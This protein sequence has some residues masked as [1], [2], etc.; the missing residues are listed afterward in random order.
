MAAIDLV[1]QAGMSS[2]RTHQIVL[3]TLLSRTPLPSRLGVEGT[4]LGDCV[5]EPYGGTFDLGLQ[6]QDAGPVFFE[7]KVT[8]GIGEDQIAKQIVALREKGTPDSQLI[9]CMI[10][11]ARFKCRRE[12]VESIAKRTAPK[13]PVSCVRYV[14]LEDLMRAL[15]GV[16]TTRGVP[17]DA[18]DLASAYWSCLDVLARRAEEYEK[19]PLDKWGEDHWLGFYTDLAGKL[20]I[21]GDWT[22][23]YVSNRAGGFMGM[24]WG[25]RELDEAAEAHAYLQF[26]D[27]KPCFKV[28]V[29]DP[30]RQS[31][32]R[33]AYW[34]VVVDR[35]KA[36]GCELELLRRLG[37]GNYMTVAR[38]PQNVRIT[39]PDGRMDWQKIKAL[40]RA[41]EKVTDAAVREYKK[42]A[43]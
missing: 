37:K 29:D 12:H 13:L 24:W 15:V 36:L 26:E 5:W 18:R 11:S 21:G 6:R 23:D 4:I 34:E 35:A 39:R 38:L 19:A 3:S 42:R 14:P 7:L 33:D 41:M 1:L 40:V 25:W 27:G 43:K 2:E 10:G 16:Q 30:K 8:G 32:I 9:Y 17:A 20:G 31:G 28:A 22:C